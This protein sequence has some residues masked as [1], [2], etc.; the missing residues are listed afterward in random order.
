MGLCS[1]GWFFISRPRKIDK[2]PLLD[3]LWQTSMNRA[4]GLLSILVNVN[5]NSYSIFMLV[6]KFLL[7]FWMFVDFFFS[8]TVSFLFLIAE[9]LQLFLFIANSYIVNEMGC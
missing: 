5:R 1:F 6:E 8:L 7:T 3:F 4:M 2:D 9:L